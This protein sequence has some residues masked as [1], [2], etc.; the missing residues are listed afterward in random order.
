MGP[1]KTFRTYGYLTLILVAFS[2]S[3]YLGISAVRRFMSSNR[4]SAKENPVSE[5]FTIQQRAPQPVMSIRTETAEGTLYAKVGELLPQVRQYVTAQGGQPVGAPF[6][7]RLGV[8]RG[9][10]RIEAGIPVAALVPGKDRIAQGELPGGPTAVGVHVGPYQELAQSHQALVDWITAQGREP[11]GPAW[12]SFVIGRRTES[13]SSRW[14]TE[15]CIPLRP[16][17]D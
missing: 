1:S 9:A 6:C 4:T 17:Q 12:F 3:V 16:A 8:E 15:I 5:E 11:A 7:R 10:V 13:D 14:R 2:V